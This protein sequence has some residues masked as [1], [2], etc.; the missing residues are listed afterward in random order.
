MMMEQVIMMMVIDMPKKA[1]HNRNA[2]FCLPLT[3]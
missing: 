1:T 3:L 2:N